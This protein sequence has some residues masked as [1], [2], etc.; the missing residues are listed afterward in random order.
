M[1]SIMSNVHEKLL[2]FLFVSVYSANSQDS[3]SHL[4]TGAEQLVRYE[5]VICHQLTF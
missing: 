5:K 2:T 1:A 4:Q 3:L